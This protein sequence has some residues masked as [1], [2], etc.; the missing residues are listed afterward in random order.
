MKKN[1]LVVV[2][3]ADDEVLGCGG[4][5]A[6]HVDE[7]DNVSVLFMADGVSS[8]LESGETD[9]F[10]RNSARDE[11]LR[12]LGV[13][14]WYAL[15]FP[16]N[17]M[18]SIPLL[19]VTQAL[20]RILEEVKPARVYTH[21]FGD[22]NID[23]KITYQSVITACRPMPKSS[24]CELLTFEVMSSTDWELNQN[25]LFCPNYFYD[26]SKYV[27][28][29]LQALKAYKLEMR[30]PPHSRSLLHLETLA[31]HRGSQVGVDYAEAFMVCRICQ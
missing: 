1:I 5:I 14:K 29:K 9:F 26:I 18:D 16:D 12:I 17:Q 4:T 19:K 28:I 11:A 2:A 10:K 8:R 7:G 31:K 30:A 24:V 25:N 27:D 6:R 22:L 23:H 13:K 3:H 20:E 21:H 15:D